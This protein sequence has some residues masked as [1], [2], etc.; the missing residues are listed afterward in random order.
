M[1]LKFQFELFFYLK[2][3]VKHLRVE[4]FRTLYCVNTGI[5]VKRVLHGRP[6]LAQGFQTMVIIRIQTHGCHIHTGVQEQLSA[7]PSLHS[8]PTES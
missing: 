3:E 2:S 1:L 6:Q 7:L 5:T 4:N 8:S